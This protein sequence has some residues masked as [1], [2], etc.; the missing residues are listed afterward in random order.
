LLVKDD[1][2]IQATLLADLRQSDFPFDLDGQMLFSRVHRVPLALPVCDVGH[3][4]R[5]TMFADGE[6]EP[7]RVVFAG[8]YLGG[9]FIEGAIMSGIRAADRLLRSIQS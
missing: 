7:S 2:F 6:I 4:Q 3:Y 1:A 5:L 9:P 8:D